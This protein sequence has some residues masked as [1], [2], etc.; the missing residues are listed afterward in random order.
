[1][2]TVSDPFTGTWQQALG[3]NWTVAAGSWEY[4]YGGGEVGQITTGT[5]WFGARYTGSALD[6]ADNATLLNCQS[7]DEPIRIGPA[8]RMQAGSLSGYAAV[9]R[10]GVE[11]LLVRLDSGVATTLATFS[12]TQAVDT[13]YDVELTIVG[14]SLTAKVAGVT[15]A[16][17]TDATY[18]SGT[19]GMI[20]YGGNSDYGTR[21]YSFTASDVTASAPAPQL[22][23]MGVG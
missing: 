22:M 14:S 15:R 18:A 10:G 2:A 4:S 21:A 5:T 23:L 11:G 19:P 12:A 13:P 16:T 7:M 3:A 6:T 17:A 20:A 9:L 1:M 8:V